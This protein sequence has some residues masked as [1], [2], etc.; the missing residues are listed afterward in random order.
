MKIH[1]RHKSTILFQNDQDNPSLKNI[2]EPRG[3]KIP[4]NKFAFVLDF[5]YFCENILKAHRLF[6][7]D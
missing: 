3:P 7:C 2:S 5:S 6:F 1:I 4:K